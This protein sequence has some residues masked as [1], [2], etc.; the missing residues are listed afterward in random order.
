MP[1]RPASNCEF[2]LMKPI[3][4]ETLCLRPLSVVYN[5]PSTHK[6]WPGPRKGQGSETWRSSCSSSPWS[7]CK[8]GMKT[9]VE[10]WLCQMTAT[11][12]WGLSH[13]SGL[14]SQVLNPCFDPR[15]HLWREER[16]LL[17][18]KREFYQFSTNNL[19]ATWSMLVSVC[20][21]FHKPICCLGV[22]NKFYH[23]SL[24]HLISEL[25]S[26]EIALLVTSLVTLRWVGCIRLTTALPPRR[27]MG[28]LKWIK[29]LY[30]EMQHN[31]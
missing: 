11:H 26:L 16:V 6:A 22:R 29:V 31:S 10:S 13:N 24:Q 3:N 30:Q 12:V 15:W 27:R 17:F 21:C 5:W 23:W 25:F 19:F 14:A 2:W 1:D 18:G 9:L 20:V 28:A 4:W 7:G 8:N